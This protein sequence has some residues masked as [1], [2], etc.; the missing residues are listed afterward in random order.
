[1]FKRSLSLLL[2]ILLVVSMV[3]GCTSKATNQATAPADETTASKE[4]TETAGEP[5]ANQVEQKLV[6]NIGVE[7]KTI[8]PGLNAASDGGY[9]INNMF[10]GLLREINGRLEPAM[11]ES[12]TISDDGLVYTFKIRDAKWSDG[13]AITANDFVYSWSRVL[14]PETA[15]EYAWIFDEANVDSFRAVDDKT[16]EVTL[17]VPTPY[18]LGLA[19]FGTFF[20]VREDAVA[21]GADGLWAIDPT[22]SIVNGPF[23]LESYIGGDKIV[24]VKNPNYWQ[25]DK[26]K[27]DRIEGL[28]IVDSSTALTAYQ[29]GSIDVLQTPPTEEI[30]R[31]I[32][33]DPTFYIY[34]QDGTYY[35]VFNTG[36]AP[37]DDIRVRKAL[38]LALD[39]KALCET[40]TKSGEIPA[41]NIVSP[42][43]LDSEGNIF[44]QKLGN[45]D[46]AETAQ[47]EE[48]QKL[49]AE[50]GYPNG[51]GFPVVEYM[52]STAESHKKIAEAIQAMWKQNLNIEITLANQEWAVFGDTRRAGN[53][54]VCRGG[55]KGDYSDPMTYLG[56]FLTD[57]P[58]NF[59][60]WENAE[61]DSLLEQAREATG[62]DRFD[63]LYKAGA[64]EEGQYINAP[65]YTYTNAI[66]VKD[67]VVGWEMNSRSSWFFGFAEIIE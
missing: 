61:Y 6:W 10:E 29:S 36:K 30:P 15:S 12:Y 32:A 65:L 51:E 22:T 20:P 13:K 53:F 23:M 46:L 26:V 48:A 25:A 37:F 24:L 35:V 31:L 63:L 45:F 38:S 40:V 27:L 50:A 39:R 52:Y 57:S 8:D 54:Q 9:I 67:R 4:P 64:I 7:P 56:M 42:T 28:M 58:M 44:S 3:S 14:D 33:E 21:K 11:A 2:I 41:L 60:Q 34:P 19:A 62:K 59:A 49:L 1:M 17:K 5:K 16:F 18:F 43:S 55:W 47:V 66:M